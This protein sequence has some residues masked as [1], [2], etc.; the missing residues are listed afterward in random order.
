MGDAGTLL[1]LWL[2]TTLVADDRDRR[3]NDLFFQTQGLVLITKHG[4][5]NEALA[6]RRH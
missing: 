6:L 3:W 1:V 4:L 2:S 5:F